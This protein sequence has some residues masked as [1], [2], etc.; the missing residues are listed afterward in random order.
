VPEPLAQ[1]YPS[2]C[3]HLRAV[4]PVCH[5]YIPPIEN[6]LFQKVSKKLFRKWGVYLLGFRHSL[7][8]T[9][10]SLKSNSLDH[11]ALCQGVLAQ[12]VFQ[13]EVGA[14][15]TYIASHTPSTTSIISTPRE[16]GGAS[17]DAQTNS[18]D[19]SFLPRMRQERKIFWNLF[20]Q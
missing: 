19:K 8:F 15:R 5:I 12:L 4:V 10:N 1:L 20:K 17:K 14:F 16:A 9:K 7:F 6:F 11:F 18:I 13:A 2:C 3:L